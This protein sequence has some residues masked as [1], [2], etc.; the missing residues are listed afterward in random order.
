[1]SKKSFSDIEQ[2]VKNAVEA[3][4]PAFD[5][6][7]WKKMET[8]LDKEE[9]RRRPVVFWLWWLLPLLMGAGVLSYFTFNK[10]EKENE[11]TI[12]KNDNPAGEKTKNNA[13]GADKNSD[14]SGSKSITLNNSE[15]TK[16]DSD[17][18]ANDVVKV[19]E[20][21]KTNDV[22]KSSD[23]VAVNNY[24][25]NR[26]GTDTKSRTPDEA[27]F[28]S[29]KPGDMVAGK[30]KATITPASPVSDDEK[31]EDL[32][33]NPISENSDK[34]KKT[35]PV[36]ANSAT[37]TKP[38]ETIVIKI[39]TDKVSEKEIEKIVDSVITKSVT[40]KKTKTKIS[41][42][43][44]IVAAG[45]EASGVKLFSADKITGRAG[46]AVGYQVNKNISVQTGFFV[47]NKKYIA[48]K[49]DYK[50]KEGSYWNIVDI[51]SIDANCRV[52]EIPLQVRYDF[53]PGKKLNIFATAGLSSY[54]MQ[55]E[56]YEFY[57]ERYGTLHQAA[58]KYT[59]NKNLFSVLRL[60]AG[61]EKKISRQFAVF[62]SSGIAVPLAGV[63]DGKVKLY[64]TD[65][66]LGLKFT[67]GLK[68][69]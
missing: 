14:I 28:S 35:E 3:Y 33:G 50:T 46:L 23:V 59:G 54:I 52:Y 55:K 6:Q 10:G 31:A 47:S 64:S 26:R 30:T 58:V 60:S 57:Y 9:D 32:A 18:N 69:K 62:A 7:A 63:G 38:E 48:G 11:L 20:V 34:S 39:D 1:M 40:D 61:A 24:K 43:Y 65:I 37:V 45:A 66:I 17:N 27:L 8:L 21:V 2:I 68:K 53:T 49:E 22:V 36:N 29:K 5:E 42:F 41:K 16:N 15:V 13:A 51:K 25:T 12:Q 67:P 56:D 4:E 19:T 44:I